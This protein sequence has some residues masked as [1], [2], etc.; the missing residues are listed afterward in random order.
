MPCDPMTDWCISAHTLFEDPLPLV[1]H[2]LHVR[3]QL[4]RLRID[5][6]ELLLDAEGEG[7]SLN[8]HDAI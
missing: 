7:G 2:L 5:D 8:G 1:E 4:P 3:A 6:L